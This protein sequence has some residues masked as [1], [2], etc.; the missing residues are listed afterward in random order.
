MLAKLYVS[1]HSVVLASILTVMLCGTVQ[2]SGLQ[3]AL[4]KEK[5]AQ[6]KTASQD[7]I[8]LPADLNS[9]DIDR[10]MASLSD[11]QVRP[12]RIHRR[13]ASEI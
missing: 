6:S 5:K 10:V 11:E 2:A 9:A 7:E 4:A 8:A 1:M 13:H 12:G 3:M